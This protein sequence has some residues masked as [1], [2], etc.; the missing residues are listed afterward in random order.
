MP[1]PSSLSRRRFGQLGLSGLVGAALGMRGAR[2]EGAATRRFLFLFAR[3]GWDFSY[4][5]AHLAD[6]PN[7]DTD[8]DAIQDEAHGI[9]YVWGEA[10]ESVDTFFQTWG[11]QACVINGLE[12]PSIT[13]ERCIRLAFTG[14]T[15]PDADDFASV[16]AARS[17]DALLLPHTVLSGPTFNS[18][19]G[20]QVVRVG[21]NGQ[22]P[23]LIDGSILES[24]DLP[25]A[26]PDPEATEKIDAF[27]REQSA[28][29][30]ALG[31]RGQAGTIDQRF[32]E[33]FEQGSQL[34]SSLEGLELSSAD[35][36][37]QAQTALDL[38]AAGHARCALVEHLGEW[39][40]SW[41]THA[42][43]Q[44]QGAHFRVYFEVLNEIMAGLAE[45]TGPGG[46][47]LSE[48]V[49]VVCFS[50]MGRFPRFNGQRGKDHWTFT[51]AMLV[52]AGVQGGTVVGAFEEDLTGAPVDLAS[53]DLSDTGEVMTAA[54]LG[55]TLLTMG[56]VDPSEFFQASPVTG[57]LAD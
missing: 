5:F 10:R 31:R 29:R 6:N 14:T 38:F 50:E 8:P 11:D 36:S 55:A 47:P 19:F 13:H 43:N 28:A 37:T 23:A 39:E 49:T 7:I 57:A 48:E 17:S 16:L 44:S 52:G 51:S 18:Q 53:G 34:G 9:P 54:H 42:S 21:E 30:A 40:Q 4:T 46:G 27:L 15:S 12:V 32:A 35:P 56:D 24:S 22:L 1:R 26:L 2:A 33:V 25:V 41:D 3:G 45:R 20:S